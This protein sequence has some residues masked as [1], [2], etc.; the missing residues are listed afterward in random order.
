[1]NSKMRKYIFAI[2]SA[3]LL[4]ANAYAQNKDD[5]GYNESVIMRS[6]FSPRL[7]TTKPPNVFR[8]R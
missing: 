6:S 1:M 4:F 3:S 2:A 5:K 8:Q 7:A